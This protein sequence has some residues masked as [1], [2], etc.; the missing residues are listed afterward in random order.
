MEQF[1][2][3]V[4]EWRDPAP[5]GMGETLPTGGVPV[6]LAHR[7]T[8]RSVPRSLA[9]QTLYRTPR[10]TNTIEN[11][12][13][14]IA[15]YTCLPTRRTAYALSVSEAYYFHCPLKR[16]L[17]VAGQRDPHAMNLGS[18]CSYSL[19]AAT[20][21]NPHQARSHNMRRCLRLT[22]EYPELG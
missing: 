9:A 8:G 14:S 13:E 21:G 17:S 7:F 16:L 5:I 20:N 6:P 19:W 4:E 15:T 22:C 18:Y 2:I 11:L 3:Q 12:N 1:Q 10:S